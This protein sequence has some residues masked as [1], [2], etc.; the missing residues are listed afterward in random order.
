MQ[1]QAL[2][3]YIQSAHLHDIWTYKLTRDTT[4]RGEPLRWAVVSEPASDVKSINEMFVNET[5]GY[6]FSPAL[7]SIGD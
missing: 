7:R 6:N 2:F 1:G 4:R 3:I 5:S